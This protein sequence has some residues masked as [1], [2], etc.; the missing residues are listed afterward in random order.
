M[1]LNDRRIEMR[2]RMCPRTAFVERG[3]TELEI[4]DNAFQGAGEFGRPVHAEGLGRE[5]PT[6]G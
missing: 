3:E 2:G 1:K 4:G 5:Q 6:P